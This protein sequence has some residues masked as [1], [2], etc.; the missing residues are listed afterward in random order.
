[1]KSADVQ[2]VFYNAHDNETTKYKLIDVGASGS[3]RILSV[4][5]CPYQIDPLDEPVVELWEGDPDSGGTKL[6][7]DGCYV[8]A[9]TDSTPTEISQPFL[10]FEPFPSHY[11]L[12]N[13]DVWVKGGA[14][15]YGIN[16][17]TVTYQLGG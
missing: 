8:S 3:C 1:M 4:V 14:S 2:S 13:D 11:Y 12:F 15:G 5:W 7:V 16:N 6:Y 17:V 10:S 9:S